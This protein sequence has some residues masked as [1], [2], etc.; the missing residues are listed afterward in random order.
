MEEEKSLEEC[1]K[2]LIESHSIQELETG[3]G[4]VK[5]TKSKLVDELMRLSIFERSIN[6]RLNHLKDK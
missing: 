1:V 2:S 4:N 6:E 3:L 5:R